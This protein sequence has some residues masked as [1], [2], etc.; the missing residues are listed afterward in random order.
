[1]Q[2]IKVTSIPDADKNPRAIAKWIKD[3][4]ELHRSKPAPQVDFTPVT[5]LLW[6]KVCRL[7]GKLLCPRARPYR[8]GVVVPAVLGTG[9]RAHPRVPR[10]STGT[11]CPTSSRQCET[12]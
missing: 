11:R 5:S 8:R 9:T 1:M 6:T 2:P 10:N 7:C 4:N 12:A 3:I